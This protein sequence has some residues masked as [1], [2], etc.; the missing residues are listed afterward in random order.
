ML[1][2]LLEIY[3]EDLPPSEFPELLEQMK[4]KMEKLLKENFLD[5]SS[6]EP[7]MTVR[8]LFVIVEGL[9]EKQK[10]KIIERKGPPENVAYKD[11]KPTKALEGFLRKFSGTEEEIEL[12][13]GYVYLKQK[14]EGKDTKEILG[15]I[16]SKFINSLEFKKTM[17][18]G[19]GKYQF[20]RPVHGI[21]ALFE[22]ITIEFEVFGI[23]SSSL[24]TGHRFYG[25]GEVKITKVDEYKEELFREF[26]VVDLNERMKMIKEQLY[27]EGYTVD[28][29][30]ELVKEVAYLTEFPKAVIGKFKEKYLSLPEEIIIT[31]VKH[32]ERTFATFKEGKVSNVFVGFQ[33]GPDDP[34]GNVRKGF[35]RVINARLEDAR[36]YYEKDLKSSFDE[37]NEELKKVV[38]QQRLGSLYDKVLRIRE[39]AMKLAKEIKFKDTDLVEMAAMI[40]KADTVSKVVYEFPELQGTMGRIYALEWGEKERVAWAIE[41]Q[42]SD[43]PKDEIGAIIGFADRMDT[44]VGN[45]VIGNIPSG[46][47]DPYGLRTKADAIFSFVERFRWKIDLKDFVDF[48]IG[49][50][51]EKENVDELCEFLKGRFRAYLES[52]KV[53]WDVA[54]AVEHLWVQPLRGVLSAK[55]LN[56]IVDTKDII[57]LRVGFERI[58]NMAS[59]YDSEEYDGA[60]FKEDAEVKLLNKFVEVKEKVLEAIDEY[61]YKSAYR[62][63]IELKPY[64][65]NYFDNVFVM[66]NMED[67]RRNR[68]GFLKNV[69]S[70]FMKVADLTKISKE[71]VV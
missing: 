35:E 45:F 37:W 68:L 27:V 49:L 23:K 18:W 6:V 46:S 14:M 65:D 62:A 56:D 8:R 38:F 50:I 2:A 52:T 25:N 36:Y 21:L 34:K 59:K 11:G 60:L 13:D 15:E 26:V 42:Y 28:E 63:L 7:G 3:T 64:I 22:D 31:T 47:K 43:S 9:P 54:R 61:D 10:D 55:A 30:E 4:E 29:D 48:V 20:V 44:I 70:L 32:H 51:G 69:D 67:I 53:A 33:D 71:R 19:D 12:R 5:F 57:D 16:F 40:S 1:K 39:V 58:H 17:R 41:E 24:T 66:V